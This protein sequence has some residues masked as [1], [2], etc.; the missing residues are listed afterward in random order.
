M[1]THQI[2]EEIARRMNRQKQFDKSMLSA[3]KIVGRSMT[4]EEREA[5]DRVIKKLSTVKRRLY[6]LG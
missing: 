5:H 1:N 3:M 2:A 6:N 4:I